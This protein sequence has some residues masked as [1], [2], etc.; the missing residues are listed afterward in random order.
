MRCRECKK[1]DSVLEE[2]SALCHGCNRTSPF[3][4]HDNRP[5]NVFKNDHLFF[6]FYANLPLDER[7]LA[8]MNIA[9]FGDIS[10]HIAY[11]QIKGKTRTGEIILRA[12][13]E[14][15]I[16][17]RERFDSKNDVR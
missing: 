6:R 17:F 13:F 2:G 14:H 7:D 3:R 8:I 12:L 1:P 4:P 16:M 10:W 5:D 11:M 15:N 9:G